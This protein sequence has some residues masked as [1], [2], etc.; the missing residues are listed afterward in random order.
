[1]YE[2][3]R[4]WLGS[5]RWARLA[6]CGALVLSFD[7]VAFW[8]GLHMLTGAGVQV[9][10]GGWIAKMGAVALY[11]SMAALYLKYFEWPLAGRKSRVS[12]TCSTR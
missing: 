12:P 4:V 5:Y 2:R 8:A 3:S 11:S 6:L 10:V 9:L 1:L 7:Q